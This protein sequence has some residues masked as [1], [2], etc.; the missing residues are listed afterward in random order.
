MES[1]LG[2]GPVNVKVFGEVHLSIQ[3]GTSTVSVNTENTEAILGHPFLEQ[4]QAQARLDFGSQ[5]IVLFDEQVPYFNSKNKPK[6][7]VIRIACT[8]VLNHDVRISC[9]GM[10][11][12]GNLSEDDVVLSPTKGLIEK[13]RLLVAQVVVDA[14]ANNQIP[15]RLYNPGTESVKVKK[16]AIAGFLQA[17]DVD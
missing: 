17:A 7:P 1:L 4:A 2:I 14:Q 16:G 10:H 11:T 6:V 9:R 13:Y 5:R 12:S 15:I 8:A 3:V